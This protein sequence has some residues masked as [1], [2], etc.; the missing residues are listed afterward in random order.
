MRDGQTWLTHWGPSLRAFWPRLSKL[1]SIL[2]LPFNS[3]RAIIAHARVHEIL[4]NNHAHHLAVSGAVL[5]ARRGLQEKP[6][7]VEETTK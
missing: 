6:K 7:S 2:G 1:Y 5:A 4:V 3:L